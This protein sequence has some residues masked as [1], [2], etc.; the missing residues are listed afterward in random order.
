MRKKLY[1]VLILLVA[2]TLSACGKKGDVNDNKNV[3]EETNT[4]NDVD[5]TEPVETEPEK[6][7]IGEYSEEELYEGFYIA[8]DDNSYDRYPQGGHAETVD[9]YR[10]HDD[11]FSYCD[12]FFFANEKV[13]QIPIIS[14]KDKLAVMWDGDCDVFL[15]PVQAEEY[16][17]RVS[18]DDLGD[19]YADQLGDG[20]GNISLNETS[21]KGKYCLFGVRYDSQDGTKYYEVDTIN[22]KPAIEYEMNKVEHEYVGVYGDPG[23]QKLDSF[24]RNDEITLGIPYGTTLVEYTGKQDVTCFHSNPSFW[25]ENENWGYSPKLMPTTQGYAMMDFSEVPDGKYIMVVEGNDQYIGTILNLQHN[26]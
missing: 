25:N 13:D 10:K 17:L 8:Y 24:Q 19:E 5:E 15:S 4:E 26:K 11:I 2:L 3:I 16:Y 20:Y 14:D 9:S 12:D 23:I 18:A 7:T 21:E 1:L 22:G 6:T